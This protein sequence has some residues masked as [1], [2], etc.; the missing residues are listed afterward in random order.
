[1]KYSN[2]ISRFIFFA[3]LSL[4]MLSVTGCKKFLE[5]ERQGA[6]EPE[7]YPYPGGSG[8]YDQ[9]I[10]SAYNELRAYN[11]HS[12]FFIAATSFRSDD[13]DK[14]SSTGDGGANAI[15]FDNF[16]V[17]TGNGYLNGLW[18]G[19]YSLINAC[20][21]TIKEVN[22]N[23]LIVASDEI[24]KQTIAEARFLRGYAYFNMV[25]LFGRV[26]LID[27]LFSDPAAQNNVPQSTQAQIYQFVEDDLTYAAANLP[28]TWDQKTFPGRVTQGSA[29]GLL[30]KVFLTQKKWA[31]AMAAA[32]TVITSG[33]Y[34]LNTN[35]ERIFGEEGEN[36]P[37]SVFEVQAT[38]TATVP[39]SLGVQYAQ[40]M[41]VRGANNW[42]LGW[43]WNTPSEDLEKAYEPNDPRRARTFLYLSR[44][45]LN[46]E[47]DTLFQTVYGEITPFWSRNPNSGQLPNKYYNHKVYTR[48]E[49]RASVGSNSGYWMNIRLLRYADVVLMYAE[50]ASEL[51]NTAEALQKLEWVRARA[52]R[53]APTGTLPE[54]TTTD[55][56]E[57]REAIR[58]E[59]RVELAMEH[60]RFFD[61][62]RWG[63]AQ[64][65]LQA[66]GK[67]AFNQ[68]RD[69]LLPIPQTQIDLSNG[70]LT[71]NPGY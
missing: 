64:E 9:F 4:G 10:F 23:E 53:G 46:G 65:V 17:S 5:T 59:R 3:L 8:P 60:D 33:V 16:P 42:N 63:I 26:P 68:A 40:I 34:N 57:L 7:D 28:L 15:E 35:Y 12:Q 41:G 22:T 20:N 36:S 24:K 30:A 61:L 50:A 67:T 19:H 62:V 29:N 69:V 52:R 11:L 45:G 31:Q 71:Q 32:N 66:V 14:G 51:G 55:P 13:A 39:T 58:H 48:P 37:E 49:R 38:A 56:D 44:N 54:I 25:R 70:L 18:L 21:T 47:S 2:H 1:M 27:T 43:G 6:Y